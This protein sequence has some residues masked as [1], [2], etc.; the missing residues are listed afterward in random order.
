MSVYYRIEVIGRE[1]VIESIESIS[2][3]EV[4]RFERSLN[5]VFRRERMNYFVTKPEAFVK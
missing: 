2:F 5:E 3:A 4:E 1:G